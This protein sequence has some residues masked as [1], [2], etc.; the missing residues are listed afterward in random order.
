MGSKKNLVNL[1]EQNNDTTQNDFQPSLAKEKETKKTHKKRVQKEAPK[2]KSFRMISKIEPQ[3]AK[4]RYNVY[5]DDVFAFGIDEEVLIK[6][7]LNKGLHVTEAL[8]K[9]I[10]DEDSFHKAYQ[11]TLNYLSYS[12]R[13]EKQI[14]DYLIKHELEMYAPRMIARLKELKFLDDLVYA[15]NYVR[16][17]MNVNQKGPRNVEQDLYQKGVKEQDIQIAM[18]EYTL[19]QQ[20]ENTI[21]LA[22]KQ[23]KKRKNNSKFETIQKIKRYLVNKGYNFEQA[24]EALEAIDTEMDTDQEYQALSKQANKAHRRYAR[25]YEG[26]DLVQRLKQF[27]YSKK[28]PKNLIDRYLAE[29]ELV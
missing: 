1:S 29:K 5:I 2:S 15:E 3:K 19:D 20:L 25:K 4:G 24:D 28:Y 13:T 12:L 9:E 17:M 6:Y 18:E 16:T 26:Y 22:G 23:W 10:V 8:Q 21:D 11:K 7:E 27:L 14:K